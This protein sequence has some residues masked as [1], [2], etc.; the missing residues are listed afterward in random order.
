MKIP[1][2]NKDNHIITIQPSS[3]GEDVYRIDNHPIRVVV[4]TPQLYTPITD[5][6]KIELSSFYNIYE[7]ERGFT[8][9]NQGYVVQTVKVF[10]EGR[11]LQAQ[12]FYKTH[13]YSTGLMILPSSERLEI[14]VV[15]PPVIGFTAS[16]EPVF[17]YLRCNHIDSNP[18]ER[19]PE[20]NEKFPVLFSV[21]IRR[22]QHEKCELDSPFWD[23]LRLHSQLQDKITYK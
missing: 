6:E 23:Y 15:S 18:T 8:E 9:K 1:Y 7:I 11:F 14:Y 21:A 13:T 19:P 20:L 12:V 5:P 2:K 4:N 17:D 22:V 3:S 16:E 10:H